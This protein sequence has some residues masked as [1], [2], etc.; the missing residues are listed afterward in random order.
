MELPEDRFIHAIERTRIL[1]YPRSRLATFG[2]TNLK[3]FLVT[4]PAY[5]DIVQGGESEGVIRDGRVIAERPAIVTPYYMLNISGFGTN[6]RR[7]MEQMAQ[8]YGPQ[9]PG[10]L[11]AY[12][13]EPKDTNIVGGDP[14]AIANR[15]C[16][17]LDSQNDSGTM[18]VVGVDELWD[19]SLIKAIYDITSASLAGNIQEMN[20]FGLL[21][22]DPDM[23]V[24]KDAVRRIETLFRGAESGGDVD[25]LKRELDRWGL[26][27]R[28]QD[29]F[30]SIFRRRRN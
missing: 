15:I 29:R 1:R 19:L 12:R 3:Y 30:L 2:I 14:S 10:L 24:P 13:N 5:K 23:G 21:D 7:Y 22:P 11:Y 25:V 4:E 20:A 28:Y 17:D 9:S 8:Q 26:F 27:S 18:V 16:K 6:A